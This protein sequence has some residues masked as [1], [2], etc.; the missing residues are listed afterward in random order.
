VEV[1]GL[2]HEPGLPRQLG[3]YNNPYMI[4]TRHAY[5]GDNTFPC[6]RIHR[7]TLHWLKSQLEGTRKRG[8][9]RS[10]D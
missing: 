8:S 3:F 5:F 6:M 2:S 10:V 7:F 9:K 4:L 1:L